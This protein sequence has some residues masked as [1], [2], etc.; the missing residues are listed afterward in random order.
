MSSGDESFAVRI[1]G[2]AGQ[3]VF[4]GLRHFG[5]QL[6]R[7]ANKGIEEGSR[8][9][10]E[11]TRTGGWDSA[12]RHIKRRGGRSKRKGAGRDWIGE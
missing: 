10:D 11:Q 4:V 1:P 3:T 7:L 12:S 9:T 8:K 6:P 5:A 2:H